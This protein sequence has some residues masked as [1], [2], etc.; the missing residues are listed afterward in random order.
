M[1]PV[2]LELLNFLAY[3]TPDALDLSGMHMACLAGANGAGKSSLLDA[4]TWSLW[5]KARTHTDNELIHGEETEMQVRL[6]FLLEGNLYRVTRYRSRKGAG[7][8]HLALELQNDDQW[9]SLSESTIRSTQDRI[10]QLLR[11]DYSTFINSAFLMQGRADEFTRKTPGERKAILSDVLGLDAWVRYEE[12]AKLRLREIEQEQ[13][14]IS[15]Q[16]QDID[17]ELD[18]ENQYKDD[19]IAA[20]Q[21]LEALQQEVREAE[22]R[23]YQ[24][25]E[26]RNQLHSVR[27][28]YD[29]LRSRLQQGQMELGHIQAERDQSISQLEAFQQVVVARE[30]VEQGYAVWQSV[31]QQERELNDR[32]L[33]YSSLMQQRNV[34]RERIGTAR[35]Q[36]TAKQSALQQRRIDLERIVYDGGDNGALKDAQTRL[37]SLETREKD[38]AAWRETLA[39]RREE[40]A[41]LEGLNQTLKSERQ[42]EILQLEQIRSGKESICPL[43]RQPLSEEHRAELI[44]ALEEKGREQESVWKENAH[45]IDSLKSEIAGLGKQIRANEPELRNL[46]PLRDHFI[47]LSERSNQ[48]GVARAELDSVVV[49]YEQLEQTVSSQIFA[50]EEQAELG[51]LEKQMAELGYEESEH[52]ALRLKS[53]QYEGFES[54]KLGLDRALENIPLLESSIARLAE[55]TAHWQESLSADETTLLN[56]EA[57]IQS[58]EQQLVGFDQF[59]RDLNDLRDDEG[60]ARAAVGGA[61]QKIKALSDQRLRKDQLL[62][63]KEQLGSEQSIYEDLRL[64]FGKDGVPAMIIEAAIPEIEEGANQILSRMSDG[65]MQLRF[66]TQREKATGG[67]KETLDIKIADELGTRDYAT[68]SGGEAFRVNFAI[69]LAL[70]RL[71]AHRA[72]AQLRTLIIDEG[73][74]TQDAPGR[75]RLVQALNAI[76]DEFDLVLVITHIDELKEAFP[77]RIEITKTAHGSVIEVV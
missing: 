8:S 20:Q 17:T 15:A 71:L 42:R 33:V 12:R 43:C 34:L 11:L 69:R 60:N 77:V 36:L 46:P 19:L 28:R 16:V 55:R 24:L 5:G 23:Y 35:S 70:S 38:I 47:R 54:R 44:D 57:E 74:G 59:E 48:A 68:F 52:H 56:C 75:E 14:Q 32:L 7:S 21:R 27:G 37:E 61:E 67:I 53:E 41:L 62:E 72:G 49:E 1:I 51:E 50:P 40:Q 18:H 10:T 29:D 73:F 39:A 66:D 76:Q 65:K 64:A 4:I 3:R 22:A 45:R 2:K 6:T 25:Q 58:L 13:S 31:R 9:R 30:E 26:A 63:R